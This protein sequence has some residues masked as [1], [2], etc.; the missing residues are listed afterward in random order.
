[1]LINPNSRKKLNIAMVVVAV[2]IIVSMILAY[3]PSL[4]Q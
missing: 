3:S 2:L 1:M 4:Y